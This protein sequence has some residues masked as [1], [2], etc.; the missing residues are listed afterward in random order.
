LTYQGYRHRIGGATSRNSQ[1]WS[2]TVELRFL[3]KVTD[4]G[5]SPALYD[6]PE[7]MHGRPVYVLQ[8][9]K[10][11]DSGTLASLHLPEDETVIAVPKELMGYLP[12]EDR[13]A[14]D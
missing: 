8:G 7:I 12:E 2:N 10:I 13:G 4:G 9:W 1:I 5:N 14:A 3:G 11:T 6:T